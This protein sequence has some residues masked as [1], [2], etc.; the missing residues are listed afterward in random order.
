MDSVS[1]FVGLGTL[2]LL[3]SVGSESPLNLASPLAG[4]IIT[5]PQNASGSAGKP[6]AVND[7]EVTEYGRN[8]G[9]AWGWFEEP[10]VMSFAREQRVNKVEVL[11]L[12]VDGRQYSFGLEAEVEGQ[13]RK[14][15]TREGVHGWVT[16]I[17]A[18]VQCTA[19]RFVFTGNTL[20]VKAYHVVEAAVYDDPTPVRESTL[21]QKWLAWRCTRD[22]ADLKLL[23]VDE[24]LERVFLD[25]T[26]F[27]RAKAL[28]EGEKRWLD[29]D[30]DRDPDL[31]V[32]RDEGTVIVALDDD[33]DATSNR[34]EAD[35]DSDCWVIDLD[36]D[37]RPDRV[38]DYWDDDGDGDVDR[39]HHYYL[40]FGWF[41]ARPG[42]VVVWDYN[43]D[44]RT[45]K[46][47]R[48]SYH[49]DQCQWDCDF[50]AGG[51]EGFSLFTYDSRTRSWE[52]HWECPFYFYDPDRDGRSEEDVRME[53]D[54][55]K[56]RA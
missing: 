34:P 23:G 50:G 29:A 14:L 5:G 55:R 13:W 43:D 27:R 46:L 32:F 26:A 25:E 4:T 6:L 30:G 12:D 53:G 51:E 8:H 36:L 9:Y 40:H 47:Q 33:D 16:L 45:W 42:L 24:A 28:A 21:K 15:T 11:M 52:A 31:I 39:E 18:P 2:V 37:G 22:L 49:Q 35:R 19:L 48:F 44:N 7:G 17:F 56:M 20:D 38:L 1:S 41:G 54:G 10:L 3:G